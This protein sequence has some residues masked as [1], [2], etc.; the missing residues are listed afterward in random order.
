MRLKALFQSPGES[1][2]PYL[3]F[4]FHL[5]VLLCVWQQFF[6]TVVLFASWT[7]IWLCVRPSMTVP[8]RH[9]HPENIWVSQTVF[10]NK[11]RGIILLY[12]GVSTNNVQ[13]LGKTGDFFSSQSFFSSLFRSRYQS[14]LL[15]CG[16]LGTF[17]IRYE[18][19]LSISRRILFK[20]SPERSWKI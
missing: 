13:M 2:N 18:A 10:M 20:S 3:R 19:I 7:V 1:E 14:P 6:G 8:L 12:R 17:F 9:R 5:N 16:G 11:K 15:V 4:W